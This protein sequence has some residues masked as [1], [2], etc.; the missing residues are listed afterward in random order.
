MRTPVIAQVHGYALAG[1]CGLA[2]AC[3]VVIAA[4]D[5][6]FGLPEIKLGLLPLMVLAP[7]LRAASPRRVLEM[8][9][10]GREL[11]AREALEIGLVTRVVPRAQL[12]PGRGRDS[13]G[14]SPAS[15]PATL[16]LGKEAFYRALELPYAQ[17]LAHLRDLLTIVARS[18]DAQEGIAAFLEKR[19]PRW[20]GR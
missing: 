14:R 10:T 12:G 5:A 7:I 19:P 4:E 8:V 16:A 1:G 13:R 11:P 6:V 9:L 18:E 2:A 3:D 20:Q 15:R 17:A